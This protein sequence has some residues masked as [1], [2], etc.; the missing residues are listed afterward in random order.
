MENQLLK[1]IKKLKLKLVA[2]AIEKVY[3]IQKN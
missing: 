2:D 1:M 3:D